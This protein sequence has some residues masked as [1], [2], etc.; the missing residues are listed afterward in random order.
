MKRL[1][2]LMTSPLV[3]SADDTLRWMLKAG[4]LLQTKP[5]NP[6]IDPKLIGDQMSKPLFTIQSVAYRSDVFVLKE[7]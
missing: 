2:S 6:S 7:I 4:L 1:K 3:G 5:M